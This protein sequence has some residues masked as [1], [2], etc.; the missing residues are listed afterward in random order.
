MIQNC[1]TQRTK[2]MLKPTPRVNQSGALDVSEL[3][4]RD[5]V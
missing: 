3:T 5:S 4:L 1:Q 2:F